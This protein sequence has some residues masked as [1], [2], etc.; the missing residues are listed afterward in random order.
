MPTWPVDQI[1][2]MIVFRLVMWKF[3][4]VIKKHRSQRPVLLCFNYSYYA[5]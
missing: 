3:F 2:D 4:Y 1:P 5:T